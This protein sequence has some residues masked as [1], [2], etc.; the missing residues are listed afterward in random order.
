MEGNK[1]MF[2]LILGKIIGKKCQGNNKIGKKQIRKFGA[3][4]GRENSL[5]SGFHRYEQRWL[6]KSLVERA[7]VWYFI[8][9]RPARL[10]LQGA[11]ALASLRS[12]LR[13]RQQAAQTL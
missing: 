7:D 8:G 9:T 4:E 12:R 13:E 11:G 3:R 1:S 10:S 2:R 6:W 5:G